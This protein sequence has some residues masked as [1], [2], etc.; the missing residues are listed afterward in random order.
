[1]SFTLKFYTKETFMDFHHLLLGCLVLYANCLH[2][3]RNLIAK[4]RTEQT[5]KTKTLLLNIPTG[6]RDIRIITCFDLLESYNRVLLLIMSSHAFATHLGIM[7]ETS[8]LL[9]SFK[10]IKIYDRFKLERIF[11][12]QKDLADDDH[13]NGP[14]ENEPQVEDQVGKT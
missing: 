11:S 5:T 10:H 14:N 6:T 1:M 3:L 7:A 8:R 13:V 9:P 12:L 4:Q 2:R